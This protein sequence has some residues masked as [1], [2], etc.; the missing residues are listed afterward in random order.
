MIISVLIVLIISILLI[1]VLVVISTTSKAKKPKDVSGRIQKKGK[2]A[3]LKEAEKKLARNP[4]DITALR[5]LGNIYFE[6]KNWEKAYGVYKSL[7]EISASDSEVNVAEASLRMGIAANKLGRFDD[8]LSALMLSYKKN[9]D[10]YECNLYLG[11]GLY[12]KQVYDKAIACL[13]KVKLL[14]PDSSEADLML[15]MCFFK[16][17]KFREALPFLKKV[18]DEN[19][20]NKEVLYYLGVSMVETGMGDRALKVFIHLR[21]D[22]LF[23]PQACLEAGKLHERVKDYNSAIQDYEIALK[24]PS[25]PDQILVQIRYRAALTYIAMKDISKGLAML[26][27][28]QALKPGYKDVDTL[29]ARYSELNQNKNLQVY[30]MAGTS[31]FI[32]LC[33]NFITKYYPDATVKVTDS[34]VNQDSVDITCEIEHPKWS[35]KHLFRFYR[36]QGALSD[37]SVRECHGKMRDTKCDKAI[38]ITLGNFSESAHKF[39]EGRPIDLIEKEQLSKRLLKIS[40]I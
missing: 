17:Q 23:G 7:F 12:E 37:I 25:V 15:G 24:L 38:C 30:L 16:L 8:S 32:A 29:F 4:R 3:I 27:Q 5:E 19:P 6:D 13:K 11:K 22:P 35:A 18:I 36:G 14:K 2:S 39:I 26:K 1:G 20:A 31:E 9:P 33:R 21:P 34:E 10:S 28:V 40:M